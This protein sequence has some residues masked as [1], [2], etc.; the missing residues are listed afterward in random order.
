MFPRSYVPRVRRVR[1]RFRVRVRVNPKHNPNPNQSEESHSNRRKRRYL[2]QPSYEKMI[3]S[4]DPMFPGHIQSGEQRTRGTLDP[5]NIGTL[6][7][8]LASTSKV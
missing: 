1:V 4:P 3:R 8:N 5:G 6:P 7:E 2:P